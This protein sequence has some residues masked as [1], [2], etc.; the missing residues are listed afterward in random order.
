LLHSTPLDAIL[1]ETLFGQMLPWV[2]HTPGVLT[3]PTGSVRQ[4]TAEPPHPA[5]LHMNC[6]AFN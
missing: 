3:I 5:G 1:H 4:V 6:G 2:W